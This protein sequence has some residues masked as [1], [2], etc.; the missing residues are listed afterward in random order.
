MAD[1]T[2]LRNRVKQLRERAGKTNDAERARRFAQIADHYEQRAEEIEA[3]EE[4]APASGASVASAS[5]TAPAPLERQDIG[6][7]ETLSPSGRSA[8]EQADGVVRAA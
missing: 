5:E 7:A 3:Q 8:R 2:G 4:L 6:S 1:S